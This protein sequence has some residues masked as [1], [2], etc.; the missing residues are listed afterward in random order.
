MILRQIESQPYVLAAKGCGALC[1][2]IIF[3]LLESESKGSFMEW[4]TKKNL[5]VIY[6]GQEL[7]D[8][9]KWKFF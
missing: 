5:R 2:D 6:L 4:C 7:G 8:G 1:A 9:L 3:V